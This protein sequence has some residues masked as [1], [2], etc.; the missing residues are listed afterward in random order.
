[1]LDW[2]RNNKPVKEKGYTTQLIGADAVKYINAQ[3][4]NKPFYLYL[5][6]N[7][8][9]TPY[10]APQ[11]YIDRYKD[12]SEP[13]RR[14]YAG[15]V[16]CLDD[17]IGKVIAAIDKKGLRDN[18]LI[19]FHSDNGGTRDA[20][21]AGQMTDML[22]LV[23]PCDNGPYRGG[24]GQFFEGGGRVCACANW[25]GHIKPGVVEGMIHAVDLLP[26]FAAVA[27][28]STGKCK[29]LDGMNVWDTIAGGKPS[30]RTEV[31]YNIEP[32]RAAL[33]QGDWK[34]IMRPL[35]PQ[36]VDLYDL[37]EDPYEKNNVA[38]ANPDKVAAMQARINALGKEAAKPLALMWMVGTSMKH[39][40]PL[41]GSE[42]GKGAVM[43]GGGGHSITDDGFGDNDDHP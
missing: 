1:V 32:F 39:G 30:P 19:I 11:D 43:V 20:M 10:Q 41:M 18:T 7:A 28:A 16:S 33:R 29:P 42:S 8:P 37:A 2:F 21:F 13:T 27:G 40:K 35:I 6:F 14:T 23:L 26:T 25:P 36:S 4:P 17:E 15:M 31:V 24:K 34:I 3:D 38:A 5:T 22:K 9:H 12:I